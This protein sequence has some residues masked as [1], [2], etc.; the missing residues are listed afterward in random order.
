MKI[1]KKSVVRHGYSLFDIRAWYEGESSELK[2]WIGTGFFNHLFV[3]EK[4]SVTLYYEFDEGEKIWQILKENLTEEFF[5]KLCDFYFEQIDNSQKIS[6]NNEIFE[7]YV[8]IWPVLTIFDEISKYPEDLANDHIL[9]RLT[10]IRETT[11]D[12]S[13][14]LSNKAVHHKH[15]ENYIFFKGKV[16]YQSLHEFKNKN[17]IVIENE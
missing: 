6:T 4:N 5:D 16:F 10:R 9:R 14:K 1:Y 2:K 13:Y 8:K 12:F 3:I 7:I 17:N 15:P 11:Q